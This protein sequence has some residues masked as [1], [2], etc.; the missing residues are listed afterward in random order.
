MPRV[1]DLVEPQTIRT[2]TP[3]Y[4]FEQGVQDAEAGRVTL[5]ACE[6]QAVTAFVGGKTCETV[7]LQCTAGALEWSCSCSSQAI[8][9]PC[10]HF[11]AVALEVSRGIHRTRR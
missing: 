3:A 8:C 5:M 6:P 7:E 11:V 9:L 1:A 2:W 4:A 10:R